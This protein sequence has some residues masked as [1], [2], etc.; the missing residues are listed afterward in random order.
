M[1]VNGNLCKRNVHSLAKCTL[2]SQLGHTYEIKST[3]N[4]T[5]AVTNGCSI[6]KLQ[7]VFGFSVP[8]IEPD[9]RTEEDDGVLT[10][11]EFITSASVEVEIL[12]I[13]TN[14]RRESTTGT[15][16]VYQHRRSISSDSYAL[17]NFQSDTTLKIDNSIL[18]SNGMYVYTISPTD[19]SGFDYCSTSFVVV[20]KYRP[21][22]EST[23][24]A[25][26]TDATLSIRGSKSEAK[27]DEDGMKHQPWRHCQPSSQDSRN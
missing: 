18:S 26:R 23:Q 21:H 7:S 4:S 6:S 13:A 14:V 9:Q 8:S 11:D 27:A 3:D 15:S 5:S 17:N 10:F 22:G 19:Y 20:D 16:G 2:R 24:C 12:Q 25:S 1:L